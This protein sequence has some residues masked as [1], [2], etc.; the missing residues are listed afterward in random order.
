MWYDYSSAYNV[1]DDN[2]Q[3]EINIPNIPPATGGAVVGLIVNITSGS[4]NAEELISEVVGSVNAA[5]STAGTPYSLDIQYDENTQQTTS[6]MLDSGAPGF[7]IFATITQVQAINPPN[8]PPIASL[9]GREK[10]A[11]GIID[12]SAAGYVTSEGPVDIMSDRF[13]FIQCDQ[14][15]GLGGKI[16]SLSVTVSDKSWH[17]GMVQMI[18]LGKSFYENNNNDL[19]V[20]LPAAIQAG[21]VAP[22]DS[23][24]VLRLHRH[25]YRY[26]QDSGTQSVKWAVEFELR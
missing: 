2:N 21:V 15:I 12:L 19:W 24:L 16:Q 20:P 17:D 26:W 18:P 9:L 13:L 10:S 22:G 5:L 14:A 8:A 23:D 25:M 6:A 7:T 11:S 3:L 1:N 4:Y